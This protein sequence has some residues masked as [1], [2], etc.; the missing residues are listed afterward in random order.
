MYLQY[1]HWILS[2]LPKLSPSQ[3]VRH[4]SH[5]EEISLPSTPKKK[6]HSKHTARNDI[7]LYPQSSILSPNRED[8]HHSIFKFWKQ[9]DQPSLASVMTIRTA[10]TGASGLR[11]YA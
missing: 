9:Q 10:L 11:I 3:N 4:V 8:H 2:F 7:S 5:F 1:F 6:C